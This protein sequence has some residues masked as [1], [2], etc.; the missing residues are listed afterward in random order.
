MR[1]IVSCLSASSPS[2]LPSVGRNSESAI[3]HTVPRTCGGCQGAGSRV[4][5]VAW[6]AASNESDWDTGGPPGGATARRY[7]KDCTAVPSA[8]TA[9][10]A[11]PS[12][13]MNALPVRC[14]ISYFMPVSGKSLAARR[15]T[16]VFPLAHLF[17]HVADFRHEHRNAIGRHQE[18]LRAGFPCPASRGTRR[19]FPAAGRSCRPEVSCDTSCTSTAL[20]PGRC[21][22]ALRVATITSHWGKGEMVAAA[23]TPLQSQHRASRADNRPQGAGGA[24]CA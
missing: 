22:R 8:V 19:Y 11:P 10:A 14:R 17:D 2:H 9:Q 3:G 24:R 4:D 5:P 13:M 20:L 21:S 6:A 12:G 18:P 15:F 23:L 7:G 1:T 16:F